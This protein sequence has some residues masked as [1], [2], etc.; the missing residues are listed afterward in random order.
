MSLTPEIAV[1]RRA[2]RNAERVFF[3]GMSVV[4]AAV[5]FVGFAPTFY[6]SKWLTP[7]HPMQPMTA[8]VAWHGALFTSWILLFMLQTA[9]IA[10][11]R[12]DL[13]RKLG[14][15]GA[16]LAGAMTVVGVITAL[17]GVLRQS[18]PPAIEP[19][20]FL[21]I[22]LFDILV[23]ATL[24]TLGIAARKNLPSHKRWM[25][26]ANVGL[27]TAAVARW[28]LAIMQAGPPAFFG[29][30]DLLLLPLIAFDLITLGRVHRTTILGSLLI[31]LSQP[32]RLAISGTAAWLAFAHWAVGLVS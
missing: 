17:H 25:L 27:M 20:Q 12:P 31:V 4:C 18:G 19:H 13:H 7:P 9:L 16:A 28:P 1:P 21:T 23:F 2:S 6:L 29:G 15:F 3:G 22:P 10:G 24:V 14:V 32:L 5:V 26:I 11:K 30:T 8:W